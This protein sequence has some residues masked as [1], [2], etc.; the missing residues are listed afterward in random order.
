MNEPYIQ[1]NIAVVLIDM[2]E[3]RATLE[4]FLPEASSESARGKPFLPEASI[5][6]AVRT[7]ASGPLGASEFIVGANVA[8]EQDQARAFWL[9]GE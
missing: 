4:T 8:V 9:T 6:K 3:R 1:H 2:A 7:F 5:L